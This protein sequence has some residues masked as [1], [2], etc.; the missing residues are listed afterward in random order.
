M[1]S[2]QMSEH[3]VRKG[4]RSAVLPANDAQVERLIV[5]VCSTRVSRSP[6][7]R[8][9]STCRPTTETQGQGLDEQAASI[10]A[11][12]TSTARS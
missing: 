10:I 5:L 8:D 3:K 9:G 12:K 2:G 1:V 7:V 11:T 4:T 6:R